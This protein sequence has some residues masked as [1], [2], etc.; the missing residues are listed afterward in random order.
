MKPY[1]SKRTLF[2]TLVVATAFGAPFAPAGAATTDIS[3]VPLGTA[4]TTAVLPNLMFV[5]D[6]SGSMGRH[7][8][9]DNVDN[10]NSCKQYRYT[11]GGNSDTSC[12]LNNNTNLVGGTTPAPPAANQGATGGDPP[13]M[14][15]ETFKQLYDDPAQRPLIVDVRAADAYAQGHIAGAVS[16]PEA[17]VP[18]RFKEIPKDSLV[19]AYCQ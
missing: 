1:F 16:I 18:T 5:L 11:S 13:R 6:D 9:P 3:Q 12:I 17:D 2:A 10:S 8:M 19:V 7:W 14:S 15:L 4:S